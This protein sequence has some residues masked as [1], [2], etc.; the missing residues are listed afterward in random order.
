MDGLFTKDSSGVN[1]IIENPKGERHE[2]ALKFMFKASNNEAQYMGLI[3][4][5]E[6]CYTIRVDSI[7]A[8]SDSQL[9]V[10]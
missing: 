4:D 1:L 7:Q 5:I 3:V 9:I 8:F 2:H 10:S 6:L